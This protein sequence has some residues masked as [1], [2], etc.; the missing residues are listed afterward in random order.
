VE[1]EVAAVEVDEVDHRGPVKI[2]GALWVV[3]HT[4]LRKKRIKK[5][6]R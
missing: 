1:E 4:K 2:G 3:S 6:C 5:T